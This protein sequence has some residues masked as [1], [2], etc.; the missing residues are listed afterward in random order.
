INVTVNVTDN[1]GVSS[2]KAN[3]ISLLYQGG[4]L[5][6]GSITALE[7][8]HYVN[9]SAVDES[10]NVAWNNSTTYTAITPD[11]LPPSSINNLQSTS[12]NAWIN[13]TWKNPTDP[14]FNHTEIYFNNVFQKN[15]SDEYFN[16]TDLEPET[17][18]TIGTRTVDTSGNVNET[19]VN[20]TA[21]TLSLPDVI[22][23]VIES[24]ILFPTNTTTGSLINVT[25]NVTDNIGVSSVKANNVPLLNQGGNLWNGSITAL[26]GTHYVNV[27]AVDESGNVAWNNSTAYTALTPDILPPSSISNL[28]STSGNTWIN[29]TWKNP[30]DHDFNHTEIYL[31]DIFQKNTSDEYFNATGLQPET[32]YTIGTRTVDISGNVNETWVNETAKTLSLPDIIPPVIESV[33]L[34]PTNTTTGSLINVTVNVT[35]NLGVSGVKANEI[36]L[37]YQG[38]SLWNGSITALEGTHYVNV[39]AVDESGNVAWNNSTAYTAFTPDILPPS[40]ISNLQSTSGNTWINWTWQN[41]TDPDFNHTEIYLNN[42]F[43]TSTST[44]FY[45]AIGL[46]PE[47]SYT[48]STRTVDNNGNVNE[49]WVNSTV[50]TEKESV[51]DTTKPVIES[52]VLFP[53]NTT[54]GAT[55]NISVNATDDTEVSEVTAGDVKLNNTNGTW[56][57]SITAPALLGS[58][59][60]SINATDAAGN[61]ANTSVPYRVVQLSG[62]ANIAVSPRASTVTAGNTVSL[63][64]KVKNTQ[65]IDDTFTVRIS[66]SELPAAY[67]AELAWFDWTEK[68]IT[69]KA[70]EEVLLPLKVTVP[71]G[72]NAGR[73]L[74]RANVKSETSSIR[75]FDTGYLTIK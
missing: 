66:V 65:N 58:Y 29:W 59:S 24:V 40:S 47:T 57:G 8:T 54:A 7:G 17:N 26:E 36:S 64:L 15:I 73:K 5:W 74:F 48:I 70:G 41:P 11:I 37:L 39:S 20:E 34:D 4:S 22:P 23:P 31:N 71:E 75:G 52:V 60:L 18:Y 67:R 50:T 44:E 10:G 38:G 55:I 51:S 61:T 30:T 3:E 68:T 46:E 43:Q 1:V 13:W 63:N 32:N 16:A 53:A 27:S 19:W 69:L 28:Q 9:V 12:G 45:N 35:D 2:V 25:V 6:N 42:V 56:K 62:G 72:T 49:T 33:I 21:K 14:D